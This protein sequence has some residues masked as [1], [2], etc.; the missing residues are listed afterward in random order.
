MAGPLDGASGDGVLTRSI[1]HPLPGGCRL[2]RQGR[3]AARPDLHLLSAGPYD[4]S[5]NVGLSAVLSGKATWLVLPGAGR[6]SPL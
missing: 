3:H 6:G 1:C 4:G 2:V 5:R